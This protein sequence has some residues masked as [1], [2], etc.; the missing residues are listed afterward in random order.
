MEA[1]K[2]TDLEKDYKIPNPT[3]FVT[4]DSGKRQ[5]Y[6]SGMKRD[7]QDGK[8]MFD[9]CN[10]LGCPKEANMYYRWAMLMERGMTKYGYRN[11][12]LANS[13]DELIRFK[14]SAARHFQQWLNGWDSEEDHAAA[15][16]FNIQAFEWLRNKLENTK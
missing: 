4:K 7:L 14:Q 11:W 5:E 13:K 15:V 2:Q 8:P 10:P 3:K 1:D 9:L 12:E 6:S 16:F